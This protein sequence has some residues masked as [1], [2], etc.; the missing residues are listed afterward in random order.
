[1]IFLN[2]VNHLAT[3]CGTGKSEEQNNTRSK[4]TECRGPVP[5]FSR[6]LDNIFCTS[7]SG[8]YVPGVFAKLQ[9]PEGQDIMQGLE[10]KV[11]LGNWWST[12]ALGRKDH[13]IT[14][15]SPLPHIPP[16]R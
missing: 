13:P 6:I 10:V 8:D 5:E 2:K 9:P 1:M 14:F 3:S 4:A 11:Q 12:L 7:H 16:V 15:M